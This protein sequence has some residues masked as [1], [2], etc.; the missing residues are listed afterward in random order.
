MNSRMT[1]RSWQELCKDSLQD[2]DYAILAPTLSSALAIS[3]ELEFR[4]RET[5]RMNNRKALQVANLLHDIAEF[6]GHPNVQPSSS[7]GRL[8][9]EIAA[10]TFKGH[11]EGAC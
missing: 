7:S 3:L 9:V 2:H 1:G 8:A 6:S 10:E 5:L 11:T 4:A